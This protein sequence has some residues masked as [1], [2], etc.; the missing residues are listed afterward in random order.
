MDLQFIIQY[1]KGATN[2]AADALSRMPEQS[3][4][5]SISV[6]SPAWMEKL[7]Q[8]YED[9]VDSKQL[10]IELSIQ[11]PNDKGFALENVI[12]KA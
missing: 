9:D 1:K 2:F 10:L 3:E 8:G 5:L 4:L 12:I 6:S 7:Q 11:S